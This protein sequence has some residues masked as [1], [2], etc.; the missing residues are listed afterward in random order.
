MFLS[1]GD[2]IADRR[3]QHAQD[4]LVRGDLG[5]ASDLFAQAAERAPHFAS[6]WFALGDVREQLGDRAGAITAFEQARAGD[7]EDRN[8]AGLRLA[9]LGAAEAGSAMTPGYVR[10]VFD[11]YAAG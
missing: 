9:R 4:F 10:A 2:L 7:A 5:A 8:G 3:Y 1:S 11:Q 6:A